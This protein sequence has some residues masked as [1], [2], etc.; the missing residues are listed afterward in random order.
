M[1]LKMVS[2]AYLYIMIRQT[3]SILIENL[4]EILNRVDCMLFQ[5][6]SGGG[7]AITFYEISNLNAKLQ[8]LYN[9]VPK[10]YSGLRVVMDFGS[11]VASHVAEELI[12][13]LRKVRRRNE[14]MP[15]AIKSI[16]AFE[17]DALPNNLVEALLE[18]YENVILSTKSE[19]TILGLNLRSLGKPN[20]AIVDTVS[21]KTL[22]NFV[23]KH[24]EVVIL[25]LMLKAPMCGYELIRRIYQGYYT[26]LSQGTVY[27]MLYAMQ[28]HGFLKMVESKNPRS[29]VYALTEKGKEEAKD[30]I[31]D[32]IAAQKYIMESFEKS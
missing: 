11:S 4:G 29:K 27:P 16:I 6:R 5:S 23:K 10:N 2:Y 13:C 14:K 8:E 17:I 22:E 12:D 19:H 3:T 32:F 28:K 25:S 15:F 26:F 31:R 30:K 24:L 1:V 21:R 9:L 20:L 7:K 18:L